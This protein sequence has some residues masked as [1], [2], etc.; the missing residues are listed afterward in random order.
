MRAEHLEIL[1]EEPSMEAFLVEI[2]P[3]ILGDRSTFTIHSHQGKPDLLSK[4]A[5][6]LRGYAKWLP[7]NA[8]IAVLV[9]RDDDDCSVLKQELENWAAE[10]GLETPQH[11]SGSAWRAVNGIA[12]E[13]L[14]A[15]FFGEWA[16]VR[17][18]YPKLSTN[19]PQQAPYRNCDAISGGTWEAFERVLQ[20][21]GYFTGGLRKAEAAK[22][23][24]RHFDHALCVSPSFAA[25][26][27]ALAQ[28]TA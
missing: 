26:R 6:R 28:A 4:L 21:R 20:R 14:E 1:V 7:Q 3:G 15:W 13:E 17:R 24:G 8:R 11:V 23:I 22:E 2:L 9:D 5:G 19:I 12:V 27:D 18:A 25:F 10:A 16:S